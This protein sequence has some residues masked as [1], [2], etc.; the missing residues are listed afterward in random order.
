MICRRG[1]CTHKKLDRWPAHKLIPP[2]A[3]RRTGW[4]RDPRYE[5]G[6]GMSRLLKRDHTRRSR[7]WLK[8]D[9]R[10]QLDETSQDWA[11]STQEESFRLDLE[12]L[13]RTIYCKA[14]Y[15]IR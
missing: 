6:P 12:A 1:H 2:C 13:I 14:N 5:F 10:R 8:T 7:Q 15:A 9:L 11:V 4:P 3:V